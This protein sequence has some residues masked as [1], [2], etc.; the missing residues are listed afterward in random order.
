MKVKFKANEYLENDRS[1]CHKPFEKNGLFPSTQMLVVY[2]A[3]EGQPTI[4]FKYWK[5]MKFPTKLGER[6]FT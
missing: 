4:D 2:T 1:A 5:Y 3:K 6:P